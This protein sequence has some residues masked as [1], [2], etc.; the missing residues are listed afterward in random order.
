MTVSGK[1]GE[2]MKSKG[3]SH[4]KSVINLLVLEQSRFWVVDILTDARA[5]GSRW[6]DSS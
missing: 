5:L 6:T 2:R 4:L 3:F 1:G